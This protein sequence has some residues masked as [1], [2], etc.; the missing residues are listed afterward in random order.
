M[1]SSPQPGFL[2][3]ISLCLGVGTAHALLHQDSPGPLRGPG[4]S[5]LPGAAKEVGSGVEKTEE[6][7]RGPQSPAQKMWLWHGEKTTGMGFWRLLPRYQLS[8]CGCMIV[9]QIPP[10]LV[11]TQFP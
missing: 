7:G 4:L 8:H 2:A 5:P 1:G 11:G 6:G 3:G 9:G 10:P